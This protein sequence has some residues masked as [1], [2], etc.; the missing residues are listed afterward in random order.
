MTNQDILHVAF[1]FLPFQTCLFWLV[2][3]AVHYS[4]ND[5]PKRHFIAYIFTCTVLYLCHGFFFTCGLP[6]EAECL[7]TLCSLSV[8]PLFYGYLCRLTSEDYRTG[9]LLPWLVPGVVVAVAKFLLPDAGIDRLRLLLFACQIVLVCYLG[10][11]K[12]NAFDQ[13]LQAVYADTEARDTTAVH[14]LLVAII[15]VSL[16]AGAANSIGKQFFGE[17]LWLLI[18]VSL[19]FTT[20]QFALSYICYNRD[21]TI[22]QLRIDGQDDEL[23]DGETIIQDEAETI[24]RKIEELL[25]EQCYFKRKD[26]KIGD[27]AKEIGSN[28]TY[29]SNYINRRYNCSFSDYTNRKRIEHAKQLL[30]DPSVGR[31]LSLIAEESGFASEQSFYRNFKKFVG[32]TPTEWQKEKQE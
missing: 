6:Y 29:V 1:S 19:A 15:I 3:F 10:I 30:A 26:L 31:K 21:F 25:V 12:L 2:C 23:A 18:P 20:M 13:K 14:H 28:R 16:L 11:R 8:Y 9:Q 32:M 22:D 24:G 7:W 5:G 17:S 4:K 27:L